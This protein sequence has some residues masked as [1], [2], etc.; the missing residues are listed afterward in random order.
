MY[1]V[2]VKYELRRNPDLSGKLGPLEVG[3]IVD[4][5]VD[6]SNLRVEK[7][8]GISRIGYFP[9]QYLYETSS[10]P[11]TGGDTFEWEPG[12]MQLTFSMPDGT[13]VK[14]QN[15]ETVKFVVVSG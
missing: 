11:T 12:E 1:Q 9:M 6:G 5:W 2:T 7:V 13:V 8:D 15:I 3:Q 14:C 10:T 4:G